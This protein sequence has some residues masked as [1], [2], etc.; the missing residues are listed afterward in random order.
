VRCSTGCRRDRRP[1]QAGL[2]YALL[3]ISAGVL[4][5]VRRHILLHLL[6]NLP[7]DMLRD[8]SRTVGANIFLEMRRHVLLHM[9][10]HSL[11]NMSWNVL[12]LVK[13]VLGGPSLHYFIKP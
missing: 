7:L 10:A 1:Y 4:L 3:E 2:D 5:E 8:V 12:A 6:G 9:L 13:S 11:L